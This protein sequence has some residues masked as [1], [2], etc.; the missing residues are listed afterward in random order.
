[1]RDEKARVFKVQSSHG[2]HGRISDGHNV[3]KKCALPGE[4]SGFVLPE[5]DLAPGQGGDDEAE[6]VSRDRG[7]RPRRGRV[8]RR[9]QGA[10]SLFPMRAA[11]PEK[12]TE[13]SEAARVGGS[14]FPGN[15]EQTGPREPDL[16]ERMLERGGTCSGPCK[17]WKPTE[18]PPVWT[19]WKWANCGNAGL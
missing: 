12:R 2:T 11:E 8:E 1:M 16:I 14:T 15:G 18:V 10:E 7:R 9:R 4:F 13:R 5:R 19:A 3:R 17:P 6:E